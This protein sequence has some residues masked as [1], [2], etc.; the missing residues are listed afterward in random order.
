VRVEDLDKPLTD[1]EHLDPDKHYIG[2]ALPKPSSAEP[3]D[4]TDVS[5]PGDSPIPARMD[6]VHG[7]DLSNYYTQAE[8][9]A[10]I[11]DVVVGE[12]DLSGYV[13]L[14]YL[15][16]NYYDA[17]TID[18][19]LAIITAVTDDHETRIDALE[20]GG[21]G[22][23]VVLEN[24]WSYR[25][26]VVAPST[27]ELSTTWRPAAA[28]TIIGFW[29][30]FSINA[31]SSYTISLIVNA[32]EEQALVFSAGLDDQTSGLISVAADETMEIQVKI[33]SNAAGAAE[34]L[35]IGIQYLYD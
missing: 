25:N 9:D 11:Q 3:V 15:E 16:A 34:D 8:V 33:A 12:I 14:V 35:A 28:I 32:V 1:R 26:T 31:G 10:L 6:H 7:I 24:V 22:D 13:T 17:A 20:L 2:E 30:R 27:D 29:G 23:P 5:V 18:A 21:G 19:L 4:L